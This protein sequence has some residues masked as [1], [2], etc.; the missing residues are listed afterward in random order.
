[1]NEL[2]IRERIVPNNSRGA[3]FRRFI[4]S[5]SIPSI[6]LAQ[7]EGCQKSDQKQF[8]NSID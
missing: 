2:P 4:A 7:G 8:F 1:M 3:L 6:V 5:R